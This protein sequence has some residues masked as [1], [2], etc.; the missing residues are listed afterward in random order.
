[1]S[2][3]EI[4]DDIDTIIL[5]REKKGCFSTYSIS[6]FCSSA[7]T[8][9]R[10]CFS[11]IALEEFNCSLELSIAVV[12]VVSPVVTSSYLDSSKLPISSVFSSSDLNVALY[13]LNILGAFKC[14]PMRFFEFYWSLDFSVEN[15]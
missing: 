2:E 10:I 12:F 1:M 11:K 8:L 13:S 7:S 15:Q 6:K 9:L 4:I 14:S 5:L 3:M